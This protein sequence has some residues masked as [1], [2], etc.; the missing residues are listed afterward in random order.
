LIIV[1]DE[2][3]EEKQLEFYYDIKNYEILPA[4]ILIES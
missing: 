4:N 2:S 3:K 1:V